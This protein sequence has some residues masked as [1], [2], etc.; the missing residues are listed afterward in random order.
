MVKPFGLI[1]AIFLIISNSLI[2]SILDTIIYRILCLFVIN[3]DILF[4]SII[5]FFNFFNSLVSIFILFFFTT[6]INFKLKK[7]FTTKKID[8]F[9]LFLLTFSFRIFYD[10]SLF[11]LTTE[12][13]SP[14]KN[15]LFINSSNTIIFIFSIFI[16]PIIEELL[17]RTLILN[18]L[19]KKYNPIFAMFICSF[20]FASMHSNIIQGINAFIISLI[21]S[22]IFIYT[23]STYF[24]IFIHGLNNII[25]LLLQDYLSVPSSILIIALIISFSCFFISFKKLKL[26]NRVFSNLDNSS[27]IN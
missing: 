11:P 3:Q 8:Y 14:E 19:C 4:N 16:A 26:E 24:A 7:Q 10:N 12:L 27:D 20:I 15:T 6:D 18:G 17:Y 9:Y 21:I 2:T 23:K 5:I 25:V 13:F 1:Y 22:Y